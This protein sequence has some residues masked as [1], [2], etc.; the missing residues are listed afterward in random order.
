MTKPYIR[1]TAWNV[2]KQIKYCRFSLKTH[3]KLVRTSRRFTFWV[4]LMGVV[5]S[6]LATRHRRL[7]VHTG[8]PSFGGLG[9]AMHW[10]QTWPVLVPTMAL[11]KVFLVPS[12]HR[13]TW[14]PHRWSKE[15]HTCTEKTGSLFSTVLQDKALQERSSCCWGNGLNVFW[16]DSFDNLFIICGI[17]FLQRHCRIRTRAGSYDSELWSGTEIYS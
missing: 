7:F 15:G 1:Q 4:S 9:S 12:V 16:F 11:P 10:I 6:A 8:P 17:W 14:E 2:L 3:S 13:L 5:V